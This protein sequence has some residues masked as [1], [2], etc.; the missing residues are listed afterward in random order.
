MISKPALRTC[1]RAWLYDYIKSG[2]DLGRSRHKNGVDAPLLTLQDLSARYAPDVEWVLDQVDAM[3]AQGDPTRP[4]ITRQWRE[5]KLY[6]VGGEV[7]A[8]L[9]QATCDTCH[10]I[11]EGHVPPTTCAH[12]GEALR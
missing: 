1:L 7:V 8:V 12:C 11:T 6:T 3:L 5:L 4:V 2:Y 10:R 9:I